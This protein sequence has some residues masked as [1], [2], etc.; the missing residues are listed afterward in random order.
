MDALWAY[1]EPEA[2]MEIEPV[3]SEAFCT[4]LAEK[5]EQAEMYEDEF[6]DDDD[7]YDDYDEEDDMDQVEYYLHDKKV[8]MAFY[9]N[10][11]DK[12]NKYQEKHGYVSNLE[13]AKR[14]L[15]YILDGYV[16]N[17]YNEDN[18]NTA[19]NNV[20]MDDINYKDDFYD[21]YLMSR[22]FLVD[23]LEY[24]YDDERTVRKMLFA[25]T[26]YDLTHDDRIRKIINKYKK[27]ENG[28][29]V[30]TC[31]IGHDFEPFVEDTSDKPKEMIKKNPKDNAGKKE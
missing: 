1:R 10:Y 7:D 19:L 4:A 31:I 28:Q 15:L 30:R 18:F 26:Y 22:L 3:D 9:L 8:K 6:D 25:S 2:E 14:R 17:L 24:Q 27:T 21:F 12:I 23:Y 5:Q 13:R 20:S 29:K 16:D 11:I